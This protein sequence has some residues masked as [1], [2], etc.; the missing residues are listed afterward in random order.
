M[1]RFLS[2][3]RE[4]NRSK[5]IDFCLEWLYFNEEDGGKK[6]LKMRNIQEI[7]EYYEEEMKLAALTEAVEIC[8]E[9]QN[10]P[11]NSKNSKAQYI[12]ALFVQQD[13]NGGDDEGD[14]EYTGQTEIVSNDKNPLFNKKFIIEHF[15]NDQQVGFLLASRLL[16]RV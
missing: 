1:S 12:V 16:L 6:K 15:V 9:C 2:T 14:F 4:K 3:N 7:Q 8:V 11:P 5:L 10:L 13:G